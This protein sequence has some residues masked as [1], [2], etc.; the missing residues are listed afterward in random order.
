MESATVG[1]DWG[2]GCMAGHP[3]PLNPYIMKDR[4]KGDV[5]TSNMR[6]PPP[7]HPKK[8]ETT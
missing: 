3:P 5:T 4:G 8:D 1:V 7:T 6:P 2:G